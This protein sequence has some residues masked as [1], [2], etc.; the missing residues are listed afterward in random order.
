MERNKIFQELRVGD[1]DDGI[2]IDG[3]ARELLKAVYLK[4]LRDAE[5]EMS[6]GRSSRILQILLNH[7][8]FEDKKEH[9]I[10]K[11][12]KDAN[13]DIEKYFLCDEEGRHILETIRS[14]LKVFNDKGQGSDAELKMS[15]IQLKA[16]LEALSLHAPEIN[17][18]LG[19]LNLLFIAAELL[20]LKD[21]SDGGIRLALIEEFK[22]LLLAL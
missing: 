12:F 15:N 22:S 8:V 16:I 7:P 1:V 6:S 19:E 9:R 5:R 21:D 20:L 4:L 13:E 18:G 2:S 11:I 17:P 3:K 14:N 10:L